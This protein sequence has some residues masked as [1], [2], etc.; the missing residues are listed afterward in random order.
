MVTAEVFSDFYCG[1]ETLSKLFQQ[2]TQ[3]SSL[4]GLFHSQNVDFFFFWFPI[5]L[6]VL[7]REEQEDESDEFLELF[8]NGTSYVDGK[9]SLTCW[10]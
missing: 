2:L 5:I 3:K 7:K 6:F 9:W 4:F 8:E 1:Q 10:I